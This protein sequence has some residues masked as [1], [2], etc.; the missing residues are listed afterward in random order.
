[1]EGQSGLSELSVISWV[2]AIQG[3]PLSRV[4]LYIYKGLQSLGH[5]IMTT[6]QSVVDE[7]AE[8]PYQMC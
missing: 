3:C 2:S 6:E 8:Q 5:V 4:L 7:E 1:M